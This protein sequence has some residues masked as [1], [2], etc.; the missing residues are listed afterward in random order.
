MVAPLLWLAEH[1][2]A[3]ISLAQPQKYSAAIWYFAQ[4]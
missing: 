3:A 1:M 2:D 4:I